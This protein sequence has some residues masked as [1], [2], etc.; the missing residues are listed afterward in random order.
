[1]R[2][3][4]AFLSFSLTKKNIFTEPKKLD[5]ASPPAALALAMKETPLN[6]FFCSL[7]RCISALFYFA[8]GPDFSV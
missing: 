2:F 8:R 3:S 4:I 5:F 6:P 7:P 1:L